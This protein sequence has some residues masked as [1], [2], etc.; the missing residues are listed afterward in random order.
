VSLTIEAAELHP[1]RQHPERNPHDRGGWVGIDRGLAAF[2]VAA[3]ADGTEVA[4]ITDAPKA[5]AVGMKR[6]RRLAK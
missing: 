2:L 6:Q 5:L 3:T 1:A 4:R